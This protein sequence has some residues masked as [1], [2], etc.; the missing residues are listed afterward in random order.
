MG[1]L[2]VLAA[3][4]GLVQPFRG[5]RLLNVDCT[6]PTRSV[7]YSIRQFTEV[8]CESLLP[9]LAVRRVEV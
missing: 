5:R 6:V 7:Q 2:E 1:L 3:W 9:F 4:L 8:R